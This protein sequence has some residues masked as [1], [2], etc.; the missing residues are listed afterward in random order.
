MGTSVTLLS[1]TLCWESTNRHFE[2]Q[3]YDQTDLC[4]VYSRSFV[5][6]KL[7]GIK[8]GDLEAG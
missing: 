5:E 4:K 7:K 2:E 8:R 6:H 1:R 3:L